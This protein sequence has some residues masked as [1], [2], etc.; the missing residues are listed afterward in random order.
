MSAPFTHLHLH[1]EFSL[2]D[3]LCRIEPLVQRA[4]ELGMDALGLTDHGVL[5]ATVDFYQAAKAAGI[6][7]IIG[8]EGYLAKGSRHDRSAAEKHPYHLT[9]LAKNNAGYQNL[10]LLATK[11]Q[12][13]G[14]Y[15]KPRFDR[16]LLAQ[17]S[18]G[19]I[20]FS[21][22]LNGPIPQLIQ[23]GRLEDARETARWFQ[24]VVGDFYLE[25]QHHD[26]IPELPEVNRRLVEMSGELGIPLVATNDV[27]YIHQQDHATQD[28]LLCI[29]T[30]STIDQPG[31]MRMDD[32]SYYLRTA[33]EMG[34]LFADLPQ[35][36]ANTRVIADACDVSMDFSQLHLPRFPVPDGRPAHEYLSQLCWEGLERRYTDVTDELRRQLSYELDVIHQTQ[37]SD[38]F[39]VIWEI[40][41]FA[42]E[43]RILF[44]VRG[45]AAASLVLYCLRVTN[46]DPLRYRLVFERFLNIERKEMPDID[47]DFQDDRRDEVIEHVVQRYGED[48]VAQIITFGTLGAKAALRDTGRALG[49]PYS[50]V[51]GVARKIPAGYFKGE[52]GEIRPWTIELAKREIPEFRDAYES[53]PQIKTLVDTGQSLEGVARNA[54]IHAAGVVISDEPLVNRV[55]LLRAGRGD[56][57]SIAV[58]QFS[59]AAIAKL[60]LLKM[61]F[62]GLVNRTIL[63]MTCQFIAETRG[64]EIDLPDVPLDDPKTFKLLSAGETTGLFQLE[65]AGMR[66]YI[67]E[68]KPNSL[69]DLS[70]M[71]ALYRPGPIEHIPTFIAAKHGRRA[72][73]YPHPILK[74]VLEE[75][76]GVIVYQDQVLLILQQ[77][78]GYTLGQADIV[79]KAM[80]KKIASLMQQEKARFLQGASAQGY[81]GELASEVW[82]LIEPFAGYAFNKAHSISYALV[83]YWTAYFKANYDIEFMAALLTCFQGSTEKVQSTVT[84]CRRRKIDV[85][86]PHINQDHAGFAI[87]R[88]NGEGRAIRF[89]LAAVKNVGEAA[90]Q[91]LV[92]ERR[93]NGPF[94]DIE[95]FCRRAPVRSLNK[96]PLEV[97]IKVGALDS[98]GSR[99]ALLANVNRI[100]SIAQQQ[101]Q[102]RETGQSTMFDMFGDSVPVPVPEIDLGGVEVSQKERLQWQKEFLGV[103]LEDHPLAR[104][105]QDLGEEITF[106]GQIDA[107]M[108]GQRVTI[109]GQVTSVRTLPTRR[110]QRT[111]AI[112]G[113]EDLSGSCEVTVWPDVY[114]RT[115]HLWEEDSILVVHGKVRVREDRASVS[116]DRVQS[117]DAAAAQ[118]RAEAASE[119]GPA[120]TAEPA[121]A[122]LEHGGL[123]D[124]AP[125]LNGA[126]PASASTEPEAAPA[127]AG[128]AVASP[129]LAA[130]PPIDSP[131]LAKEAPVDA[132]Q[133]AQ[134]SPLEITLRE[135]D[136]SDGDLALLREV[137][138]LLK[139]HPGEDPVRLTVHGE[140]PPTTLELREITVAN[141][142][143]LR[144]R[145]AA[146]LGRDAVRAE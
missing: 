83:A 109:A 89:S 44:G 60:G 45:S 105:N 48:R 111:F 76:Y 27:H 65:S 137:K 99:G 58:T 19:L 5:H 50:F 114:E 120:R 95:D 46:V 13:E 134:R 49:M 124:P 117:Y 62:L 77:F 90:V 23:E 9:L 144:E 73:S 29:Q 18:E 15:Y 1:T 115:A 146:L 87:E 20:A 126:D 81:T 33:E 12:L 22:C 82:E 104:V 138:E 40:S 14:F 71:I 84:E 145:V 131:P 11:A 70:A 24:E 130:E 38:Y 10:I 101:A 7:P 86:S 91:P 2:L 54:G 141:T 42:R 31:R 51:D 127:E 16:E 4:R 61:D 47:M 129:A 8:V 125:A 56:G 25:I 30:N 136:D 108:E 142:E 43:R 69:S 132:R 110:E 98:L 88:R 85:L 122:E 116:C 28:V 113:M 68:L 41:E 78:A 21:G 112:V 53:D 59:M 79:R 93:R 39:L 107:E 133:Q 119:G 63:Q 103:Y 97:L 34:A 55:P 35:A 36:V 102:L 64:E 52:K 92:E 17:H 121:P 128:P 37:F 94:K 106:C 140:G 6:K 100:V 75:T 118:R 143:D 3:G 26:N 32:P 123:P 96:R 72:V 66:R 139:A 74:D 135:T 80:G 67:R 57:N